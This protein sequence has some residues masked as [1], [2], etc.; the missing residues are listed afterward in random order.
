MIS[1]PGDCFMKKIIKILG[2]CLLCVIFYLTGEAQSHQL[3]HEGEFLYSHVQNNDTLPLAVLPTVHIYAEALRKNRKEAREYNRLRNA[4][5]VTYPY[6]RIVAGM[7]KDIEKHLKTIDS[8]RAR[9]V[10]LNY[11]EE[12][13]KNAFGPKIK[14][15]SIY[16]GK[17]LIKLVY[18]ETGHNCYNLIKELKGGFSARL[19]QT[20]AFLFGSN[21]KT[22]YDK[23][24][25][26][27]IEGF[28]QEIEWIPFYYDAYRHPNRFN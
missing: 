21:L 20:V 12:E 8:K 7:V 4:V 19:W 3:K 17:V 10:Y 14:D 13:L 28:V 24:K 9:K 15:L 22:P 23:Q 16:Q 2:I 25:N 18:R 6:A 11:K 26:A 5:Y 27:D 1:V